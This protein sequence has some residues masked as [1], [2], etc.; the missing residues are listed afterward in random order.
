MITYVCKCRK[1]LAYTVDIAVEIKTEEETPMGV[2][3]NMAEDKI[4]KGEIVFVGEPTPTPDNFWPITR[5]EV[6]HSEIILV[7]IENE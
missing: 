3:L 7:R 6:T 4:S 5:G 2:L 1:Y